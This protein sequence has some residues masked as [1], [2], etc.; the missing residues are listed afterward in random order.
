M[1]NEIG[2][3]RPEPVEQ[4]E[5]GTLATTAIQRSA[6]GILFIVVEDATHAPGLLRL[7]SVADLKEEDWDEKTYD[8]L[9]LAYQKYVPNKIIIR[10]LGQDEDYSA[11]LEEAA[12]IQMSWLACP[13]ASEEDDI[14]VVA[15]VKEQFG[16][17]AIKKAVQYVSAYADNSDHVAIIEFDCPG[18]LESRL[19]TFTAQEY[20]V[21]I[22]AAEAGCPVN[23]SLDGAVMP[24]LKSVPFVKAKLGKFTLVFDG[25]DVKVR[26]ALNSK[27]T[28]DSTW[29]KDTRKIKVVSGMCFIVE[30]IRKSFKQWRGNYI[31]SSDNKKNFCST[32]T[33]TYFPE[34]AP[35][36]L[37]ADYPNAI[38]IDFE[39]QKRYII[40]EVGEE[41]LEEMTDT[42]ILNYP[43]GDDV[44]IIG[45]VRFADTMANLLMYI[46][47]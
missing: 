18:V 15:W 37:S 36:V 7:K 2:Q 45:D 43:T 21:A 33:K 19:G 14:K 41:K 24:D 28:F 38:W 26:Y 42:E 30:D 40:T 20:T 5:F 10:V 25:E 27:T 11:A 13:M 32:V 16:T 39:A 8:I 3:I 17:T 47:M 6:R 23:K 9:M 46:L 44:Y 1:A 35:N 4:I 31:N 34:M 29:K 22:A 12:D